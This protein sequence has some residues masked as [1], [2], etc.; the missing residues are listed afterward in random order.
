MFPG[1]HVVNFM[2][3]QYTSALEDVENAFSNSFL[4]C[5]DIFYS[6]VFYFIK[7]DIFVFETKY[8][9]DDEAMVMRV[10]VEC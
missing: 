10:D 8:T 7:L 3:F 2:V 5:F 6:E 4:D 9:V 1:A